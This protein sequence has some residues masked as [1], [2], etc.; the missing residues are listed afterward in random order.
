MIRDYS[1]LVDILNQTGV[2]TKEYISQIMRETITK[3]GM[4]DAIENIWNIMI[5]LK[6][7]W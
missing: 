3:D 5:E 6:Y 2:D 7:E 4:D 1:D